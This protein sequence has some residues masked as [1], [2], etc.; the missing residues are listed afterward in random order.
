MELRQVLQALRNADAAGDTEAAKRLAEIADGM[1]RQQQARP[2][3]PEAKPES[4]FLPALSSGVERVKGQ[5]VAL[6]G[7]AGLTDIDAA[8]A[9]YKAQEEKAGKIF[10][11]TEKGWTE[12]PLTKIGEL[13]GGS[14]PYMVA[15]AVAGIAGGI[16]A[17]GA[18]IAGIG[19]GALSAFGAGIGQFTGTNLAA[20]MGT[21]K[22]LADTDIGAAALAA[23]PQA[24]LDTFALKMIPGVKGLFSQAGQKLTNAEAKEIANQGLGKTLQDYALSTG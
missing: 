14:L 1:I 15:P 19:A 2:V 22:R 5:A 12:A 10:Q 16:A 21:G 23:V 11:P 13:A 20:Q 4:G 9:Y 18:A 6:A 7:R 24:A 3:A 8:E 17:P